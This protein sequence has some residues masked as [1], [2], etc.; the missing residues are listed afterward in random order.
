[1]ILP[2]IIFSYNRPKLLEQLLQSIAVQKVG[3]GINLNFILA[4]DYF[5]TSVYNYCIDLTRKYLGQNIVILRT[6]INLGVARNF[7]RAENYVFKKNKFEYALFLEDDLLLTPDY[8]MLSIKF[9]KHMMQNQHVGMMAGRGNRL[10]PDILLQNKYENKLINLDEHN[11][12][13]VLSRRAWL[14]RQKLLKPYLDIVL[15]IPYRQRNKLPYKKEIDKVKLN[16]GFAPNELHS[17]QDSIKNAA[18]L[19]SGFLRLGTF[20]N[21]SQYIGKEGEHSNSKKF[22]EQGHGFQNILNKE[23]D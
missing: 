3:K 7:D 16:L 15:K 20:A 21:F 12:G 10:N 22:F 14:A 18:M 8:F 19:K 1:M 17:S 13:F 9:I 4:Q 2:V 23:I 5:N 11:W 6:S